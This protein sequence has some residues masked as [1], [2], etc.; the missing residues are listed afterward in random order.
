M[1]MNS[2]GHPELGGSHPKERVVESP[3][4]A[5]H[6]E[7]HCRE[8]AIRQNRMQ[9]VFPPRV[10]RVRHRHGSPVLIWATAGVLQRLADGPQ[11][12]SV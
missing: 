4:I 9:T 1:A 10:D 11:A 12:D 5:A 2:D 8:R 6:E 7:V 3:L